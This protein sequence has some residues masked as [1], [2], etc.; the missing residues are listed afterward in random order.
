MSSNRIILSPS[1]FSHLEQALSV[2]D[3]TKFAAQD[4]GF[5]VCADEIAVSFDTRIYAPKLVPGFIQFVHFLSFVA[6]P[7]TS[8]V[9]RLP[10][11]LPDGLVLHLTDALHEITGNFQLGR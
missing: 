3:R 10:R 5:S 9:R 2:Q 1:T 8:S 4:L 11:A 6:A 7:C